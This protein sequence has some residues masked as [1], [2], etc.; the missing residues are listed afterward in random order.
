MTKAAQS[1]TAVSTNT[2][3]ALGQR[4]RDVTTSATTYLAYDADGSLLWRYTGNSSTNRS[5][6]PFGG[7]ILAE[8]YSAGTLFDHGDELGS[9]TTSTSYNG[10]A[11]QER[12]FKPFGELWTG[13][14][15]CGLHQTFA[16][17]PDFDSETDQYNTQNRHYSPMGRWMSPD[18]GGKKAWHPDDP[19]TW[20]MYA[21][22]R[23]N[24]TTFTD[25]SGLCLEDACV[26]EGVAVAALYTATAAYLNSPAGHQAISSVVNLVTQTPGMVASTIQSLGTPPTTGTTVP[27]GT[28]AIAPTENV[29]QGTPGS[30]SQQGVV[31]TSPVQMAGGPKAAD[32]PGVSSSGQATDEHGNKLGG[33]SQHPQQHD[34]Q[35]NTREAARNK[36]LDQGSTGV[37]HSNPKKGQPHF[38]SGD[39]EG[40][41]KPNSTPHNYPE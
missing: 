3:N 17:L 26:L 4:V 2:Y 7:G 16:K 20:N 24:P 10:S 34:T 30:E 1:G 19:Q 27:Q 22:T 6:V 14:G 21:Y 9:I 29:P 18:P 15:S 41:K 37:N 39:A 36:A 32:A 35:S 33:D 28:P 5:F 25:S 12:L 8:Y 40:N 11:C 31:N 23:N 38:H 13:A